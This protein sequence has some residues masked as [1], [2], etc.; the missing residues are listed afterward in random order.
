MQTWLYRSRWATASGLCPTSARLQNEERMPTALPHEI[1]R[2]SVRTCLAQGRWHQTW[3]FM[4]PSSEYLPRTSRAQAVRGHR[5]SSAEVGRGQVWAH[6]TPSE[7]CE[8]GHAAVGPGRGAPCWVL[9][10]SSVP[11]SFAQLEFLPR[12][13]PPGPQPQDVSGAGMH[14]FVSLSHP[15]LGAVTG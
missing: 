15:C 11:A 2:N 13:S 7:V 6:R 9:H 10:P 1:S 14:L 8:R 5:G 3:P 12:P 4:E